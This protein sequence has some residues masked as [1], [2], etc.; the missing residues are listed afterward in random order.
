M[1]KL[2]FLG[3]LFLLPLVVAAETYR[4]LNEVCV[5]EKKGDGYWF[6]NGKELQAKADQVFK[7]NRGQFEWFFTEEGQIVAKVY[8]AFRDAMIAA[9]GNL[10]KQTIKACK[11]TDVNQ[12]LATSVSYEYH[13]K[14]LV[15]VCLR[16]SGRLKLGVKPQQVQAVPYEQWVLFF[17]TGGFPSV[18]TGRVPKELSKAWKDLPSDFMQEIASCEY[19]TSNENYRTRT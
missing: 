10:Y 3:C 4:S 18:I 15:C 7:T 17:E 14:D 19:N 2:F 8:P 11:L 9:P 1:K 16:N 6:L 5:V 13:S 12:K